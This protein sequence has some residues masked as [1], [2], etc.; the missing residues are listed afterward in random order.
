MDIG[1]DH[2]AEDHVP[3]LCRLDPRALD[4]LADNS[5]AQFSR[6]LVFQT[7]AII[8]NCGAYTAQYDNFWLCHVLISLLLCFLRA[9]LQ[10]YYCK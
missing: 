10:D 3:Y 6:R 9:A 5:G 2:I 8:S 4:G 1:M 7:T